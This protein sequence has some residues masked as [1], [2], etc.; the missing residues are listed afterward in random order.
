MADVCDPDYVLTD[1][2]ID[3]VHPIDVAEKGAAGIRPAQAGIVQ[4]EI[5]T[6]K[7]AAGVLIRLLA[8]E[9]L[10]GVPQDVFDVSGGALR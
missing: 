1:G 8:A 3:V 9:V 2:V 5:E 7:E 6:V 4:E 10:Y